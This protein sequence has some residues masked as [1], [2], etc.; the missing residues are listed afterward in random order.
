MCSGIAA[1]V[2]VLWSNPSLAVILT[3]GIIAVVLLLVIA[4]LR[5][6][7]GDPVVDPADAPETTEL[8][9][10]VGPPPRC[11]GTDDTPGIDVRAG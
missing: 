10:S 2:L 8:P 6:P 1:L 7:A 5:A 9:T 11:D 3:I 4:W